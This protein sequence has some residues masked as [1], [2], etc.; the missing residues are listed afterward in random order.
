MRRFFQGMALIVISTIVTLLIIEGVTRFIYTAVKLDYQIEMSRY[1]AVMKR[2]DERG[3]V[4]HVHV[5][6]TRAT[7]MAVP[8]EINSHGFRDA[9]SPQEKA[10]NVFRILLLGDSLTFG[11]GARAED[12][13]SN[14]LEQSLNAEAA[15]RGLATRIEVINT[16]VGNY[17]TVQ[18]VEFFAQ[19]GR[20]WK[21]DLVLLNYFINDAEPVPI[22]RSPASIQYSYLAML[23]WGRLDTLSRMTEKGEGFFSY[24][25]ALYGDDR[26]GWIKAKAALAKL[27]AL[28]AQDGFRLVVTLLPELHV[29]GKTYGFADVHAKVEAAAHE[30]GIGE[31]V[32]L[33]PH[34]TDSDPMS[35]WVSPDDA[36]PNG[37]GH[38]ILHDGIYDYLLKHG[39]FESIARERIP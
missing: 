7:L 18:E 35:L 15:R 30:A 9:E 28:S 17:N 2:P 1:A 4:S 14:R 37:E 8:V 33:A 24:Y 36:H 12:R 39:L 13:F 34:F 25:A 31:I 38:R 10:G 29:V 21:P 20:Q 16:G 22:Q 27:Q 32:D 3:G 19:A 11:W 5:P 23:L 26:P 6:G